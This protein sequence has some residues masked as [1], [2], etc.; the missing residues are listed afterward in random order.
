MSVTVT[1]TAVAAAAST[2]LLVFGERFIHAPNEMKCYLVLFGGTSLL[3][4]CPSSNA[5]PLKLATVTS[6][7]LFSFLSNDVCISGN[8]INIYQQKKKEEI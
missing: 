5:P 4:S 7:S 2:F 1:A 6:E 8:P 3:Q